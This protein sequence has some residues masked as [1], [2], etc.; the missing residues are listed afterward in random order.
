M[1][2]AEAELRA[3]L[4]LNPSD[5]DSAAALG[6]VFV[7]T[8][9]EFDAVPL[10][11]QS[12]GS[13]DHLRLGQILADYFACRRR[14]VR[15]LDR[16]DDEGQALET[17]V[18]NLGFRPGEVGPTL[19]A[20]LIA[21]NEERN[22]ERC[23]RSLEG[24]VDEIVLVDTGSTD[25][26]VAIAERF[27]AKVS[28]FAWIDDF[29]AARNAA[30]ELSSG[31]WILWI[32]ADEELVLDQPG[33]LHEALIRPHIGGYELPIAS[34]LEDQASDRQFVHL[35]TRLFR[36]NPGVRFEGRVHEQ[37]SPSLARL[38][39]PTARLEGLTILHYGYMPQ[40]LA[41]GTKTERSTRMLEREVTD[42]PDDPFALFNLGNALLAQRK[43]QDAIA[44]L[45]RSIQNAGEAPQAQYSRMAYSLLAS[46]LIETGAYAEA[47]SVLA[48]APDPGVTVLYL[49]A[50]ALAGLGDLDAALEVSRQAIAAEWSTDEGGDRGVI[51]VKRYVQ[52]AELLL[53]AGR[54]AEA[55]PYAEK[56]V[57]ADPSEWTHGV[58][59]K[60]TS[61]MNAAAEP[62]RAGS[63]CIVSGDRASVCPEDAIA[64]AELAARR[65]DYRRAVEIYEAALARSPED[66]ELNARLGLLLCYMQREPEAVTR[67]RWAHGAEREAAL[68]QTLVDH[69]TCRQAMAARLGISD[70]PGADLLDEV[71]SLTELAPSN[72]G[73]KLSAC[74]IVK[75][76]EKWLDGCL[77][78]LKEWADEI[79]VVD[80]GS[81]D[82][83][84]A[85][86][87]RHG[88]KV[89]HYAWSD[90]F[91]AA[92]NV[93][94]EMA[95]GDWI[96]SIDA[97]ERLDPAGAERLAE[98]LMRPQFGGFEIRMFNFTSGRDDGQVY[99]HIPLRLFRRH[100]EIR[101]EGRIHEQVL[102]SIFRLG[103]PTAFLDGVAMRHYGYS[104]DMMAER[105]KR[106]RTV[107]MIQREIDENPRDEFQWFNLANA[108][109]SS[110]EHEP[111]LATARRFIEL[112]GENR[113]SLPPG[114]LQLAYNMMVGSLVALGRY[115]EALAVI[116]EAEVQGLGGILSAFGKG[117][118]LLRLRRL[119]E[120]LQTA[121]LCME[122]PWPPELTGDFGI[123]T[124]KTHFL[125]GQ[126]LVELGREAEAIPYLE[127]TL[128]H[129]P[130]STSACFV[131]GVA[132]SRVGRWE[133]ADPYLVRALSDG[134]RRTESLLQLASNALNQGQP[135][136]AL[137]RLEERQ[138]EDERELR[139]TAEA[140]LRTGD[141]ARARVAYEQLA[142]LGQ[143]ETGERVNLAWILAAEGQGREALALVE[144]ERDDPNALFTS[145]DLL[146]RLGDYAEAALRYQ[147]GLRRAPTYAQGWLV[148]G[149]ALAQMNL[150]EQAIQC[151][152]NALE[153]DPNH[154]AA[155][156]NLASLVPAQAA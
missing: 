132:L 116:D 48:V 19:T 27:G 89:G 144:G 33:M 141:H 152:R 137:Q 153:I 82:E 135:E 61:A 127:H 41:D 91:A 15:K 73:I 71:R 88:A 52:H 24:L 22:L 59:A 69:F 151:Y 118:A 95:T 149:N 8:Q 72:V 121:K 139:L 126:I 75:N 47:L 94:L 70:Q 117:H 77:A 96:L 104:P 37:I 99:V 55:L 38:G 136:R 21:R 44:Y 147:E 113:S 34:Y 6:L 13:T 156:A 119:E 58:L 155:S 66:P 12:V 57:S 18:T 103:L 43:V 49:R 36:R 67:L 30:L 10:L 68:A 140:A 60:V 123:K 83:T 93:A 107:T 150:D 97:D 4:E 111:C 109:A 84:V 108:Y 25:N 101:F 142:K 148:L 2:H 81:T 9:R 31:D 130:E 106:D 115:E 105:G 110:H 86:A 16:R 53:A 100:P 11:E 54:P 146:Y 128:R 5:A 122:L 35:A 29:S 131:L 90:D 45:R 7:Y 14:L 1:A 85:I 120:A 79:V 78:S 138:L 125:T 92:R 28:S 154:E 129:D 145:G 50:R 133:E 143:L 102:P 40:A 17:R 63:L 112:H 74:L 56:A 87:E 80:T 65:R 3:A 114:Y 64:E 39:L 134:D 23:L 26:T 51:G 62:R 98:A 42:R 124:H 20:A 46:A 76:E 32:D